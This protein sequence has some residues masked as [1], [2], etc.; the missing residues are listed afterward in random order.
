VSD[1]MT[2]IQDTN[3]LDLRDVLTAEVGHIIATLK[4][5]GRQHALVTERNPITGATDIRGIFSATQIGRQLGIAVQ[6]SDIATMFANLELTI[7]DE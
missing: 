6:P 1:L 5:W 7:R 3:T 2:A 4:A